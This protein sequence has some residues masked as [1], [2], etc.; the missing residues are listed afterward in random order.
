MATLGPHDI[1][2]KYVKLT[3]GEIIGIHRCTLKSAS[4]TFTIRSPANLAAGASIAHIR[5]VDQAA[6][7]SVTYGTIVGTDINTVTVVGVP[8]TTVILVSVH[9][10]GSVNYGR[11]GGASEPF[12]LM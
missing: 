2:Q 12:Q 9:R 6:V 4:D 7:T 10:V 1:V 11:E 3:T 8:G 5:T